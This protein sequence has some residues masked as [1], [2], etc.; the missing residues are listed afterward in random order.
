MSGHR[1]ALENSE[2]LGHEQ[3]SPLQQIHNYIAY[4]IGWMVER[5][6]KN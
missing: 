5:R 1:R 6:G 2:K 4:I 3:D